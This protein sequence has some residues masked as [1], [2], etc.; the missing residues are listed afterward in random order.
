MSSNTRIGHSHLFILCEHTVQSSPGQ[1]KYKHTT[2]A[3]V[4]FIL[5]IRWRT[6]NFGSGMFHFVVP[7]NVPMCNMGTPFKFESYSTHTDTRT[8]VENYLSSSLQA[9]CCV[10]IVY[11]NAAHSG[12]KDRSTRRCQCNICKW[13]T[14]AGTPTNRKAFMCCSACSPVLR[15]LHTQ[16]GICNDALVL[17]ATPE[18]KRRRLC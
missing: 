6:V 12:Q 1:C 10:Q 11:V 3:S 14:N 2:N 15:R 5:L 9:K 7:R 17:L 13:Q 4:I 8:Q 18:S 16:C